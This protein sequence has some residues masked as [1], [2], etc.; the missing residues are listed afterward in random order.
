MDQYT[1]LRGMAPAAA[2]AYVVGHIA[3]LSA[4]RK[5]IAKL[6]DGIVLWK[7]RVGLAVSAGKAELESAAQAKLAELESERARLAGEA[8]D[9]RAQIE[10]MKRQLPGLSARMRSVDPDQLLAEMSLALDD[11]DGEKAESRRA[12][13]EAASLSADA[14][15]AALKA[16]MGIAQERPLQSPETPPT[17][18][19]KTDE[20]APDDST[21]AEPDEKSGHAPLDT[22][23]PNDT[24]L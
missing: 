20:P 9:L 2:R 22:D 14:A 16:K 15:L 5:D 17:S 8:E 10:E 6:D 18:T 3:S 21:K 1:D 23:P 19:K 24:L 7:N 11:V 4:Y 13:A 12:E